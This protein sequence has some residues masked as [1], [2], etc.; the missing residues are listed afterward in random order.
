MEDARLGKDGG[1]TGERGSGGK[2][3]ITQED[4]FSNLEYDRCVTCRA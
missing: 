3:R 1:G 2:G 4:L